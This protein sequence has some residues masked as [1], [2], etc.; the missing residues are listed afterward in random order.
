MHRWSKS[1]SSTL[2]KVELRVLCSHAQVQIDSRSKPRMY[3]K[4]QVHMSVYQRAI[5]SALSSC[6]VP[7]AGNEACVVLTGG[8]P[9]SVVGAILAGYEQV[10]YVASEDTEAAM[11]QVFGDG[12]VDYD[13]C[14]T[15]M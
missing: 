6:N 12:S 15:T 3:R 14:P 2:S 10:L 9:E 11:M 7:L 5:G 4:G 13:E 1:S 8:T